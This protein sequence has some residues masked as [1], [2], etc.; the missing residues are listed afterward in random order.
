MSARRIFNGDSKTKLEPLGYTS[1]EIQ[2]KLAEQ[3]DA[4]QN[5]I[6]ERNRDYIISGKAYNTAGYVLQ[7]IEEFKDRECTVNEVVARSQG[8]LSE[9]SV[10]TSI[11]KINTIIY[12]L[13]GLRFTYEKET[14]RIH[15]VN[16]S[17][18]LASTTK[19]AERAAKITEEF[20]RTVNA[21]KAQGHDV[22]GFFEQVDQK[23]L[24]DNPKAHDRTL[25]ALT[26]ALAAEPAAA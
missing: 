25:S 18:V 17:D 19:F 4:I 15:L 5:M 22:R 11:A 3:R 21:Y 2:D 26:G 10:A 12:N 7:L 24:A 6:L 13:A 23:I 16:E 14:G 9:R 20:V 8:E 1:E